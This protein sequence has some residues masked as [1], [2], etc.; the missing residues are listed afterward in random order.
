MLRRYEIVRA[1]LQ[2][3]FA[4]RAVGAVAAS[5]VTAAILVVGVGTGAQ[6]KKAEI[7]EPPILFQAA[8]PI[9]VVDA[10]NATGGLYSFDIS[11]VD[12]P[13][14]TYYLADRSNRAIDVANAKTDKFVT[15]ISATPPFAGV[16]ANEEL[17]GPDGVLT[18]NGCIIATDA[19]N[20][21]VSFTATGT[22][23][24]DLRIT[25]D[26]G[27][28]DELAPDPKDNL[29][30]VITPAPGGISPT[31][32]PTGTLISVSNTS[33]VLTLGKSIPF[34]PPPAAPSSRC[35]IRGRSGSSFPSRT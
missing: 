13:T 2:K 22:Q 21:V 24:S 3:I 7:G 28:A 30:L 16:N 26:T 10:V 6:A 4:A 18:A 33:C 17:A 20:R 31:P 23:I 5:M 29:L 35:G 32:P 12:Q 9:P 27:R 15:Q 8:V 19:G 34:Q 11:W 25:A 1:L 14:Q